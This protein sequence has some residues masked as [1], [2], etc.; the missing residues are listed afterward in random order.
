MKKIDILPHDKEVYVIPPDPI[1]EN[2]SDCLA[3]FLIPRSNH[4]I[5]NYDKVRRFGED[6][7]TMKIGG[8]TYEVSTHFNPK[9]RQCVLEQFKE[10]ILSEKLI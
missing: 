4:C 1:D 2:D 8:T 9:G 7:F 6:N 10:L 5:F 3:D